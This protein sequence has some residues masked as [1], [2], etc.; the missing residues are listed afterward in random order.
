MENLAKEFDKKFGLDENENFIF[1][2]KKYGHLTAMPHHFVDFIRQ[3]EKEL[4]AR[5]RE[6][7]IGAQLSE[8][9]SMFIDDHA[10]NVMERLRE[11]QLKKLEII[12]E[13]GKE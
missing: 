6:E 4:L 8:Q 5:V 13:E 10:F 2:D 9:E 1:K 3:R 7:V 11:K 12:S